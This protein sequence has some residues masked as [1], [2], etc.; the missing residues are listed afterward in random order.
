MRTVSPLL[1]THCFCM[2]F[3]AGSVVPG[4]HPYLCCEL[5]GLGQGEL[6]GPWGLAGRLWLWQ[7]T[8]PRGGW[9]LRGGGGGRRG[10]G[11]GGGGGGG[12]SS[13]SGIGGSGGTGLLHGGGQELG[14]GLLQKELLL[15]WH[16]CC[17]LWGQ[18][19]GGQRAESRE[20]REGLEP[21]PS[22]L[23]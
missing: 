5:D 11:R 3:A 21:K 14:L 13:S 9:G 15:S 17:E 12:G 8:S 4:S 1:H 7:V 10:G 22:R 23:G 20:G 18:R 6:W 2:S 19:T 16:Q